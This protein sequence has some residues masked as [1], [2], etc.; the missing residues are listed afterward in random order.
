M[1]FTGSGREVRPNAGSWV[2]YGLGTENENL[3][4]FVEIMPGVPKSTPAAFLPAQ[5]A[6][7]AI[8][9]PDEQSRDRQWDNLLVGG[10]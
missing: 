2:A 5:Y 3:P 8:G 4:A 9:R 1:I 7:A 6:S 10:A